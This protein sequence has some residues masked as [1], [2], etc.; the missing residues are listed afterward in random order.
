MSNNELEILANQY[1]TYAAIKFPNK[2]LTA[3]DLKEVIEEIKAQNGVVIVPHPFDEIRTTSLHPTHYDASSIDSVEVF[4]SR[5]V[6]QA[7]NDVAKDYAEKNNLNII[8]GSDAHFENEIGNAGV[9]IDSNNIRE[10]VLSGDVTVF[11]K[12][13]NI[14]NPITTK[15]LKIW[16]GQKSK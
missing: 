4:N 13:S 12:R 3:K 8:A 6:R 1:I 10:A 11:G 5:C 16:R 15:L 7:Y 9:K 2:K 14:I